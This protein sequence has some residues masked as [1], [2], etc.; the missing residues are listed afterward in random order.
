MKKWIFG[1]IALLLIL[2][3]FF[4]GKANWALGVLGQAALNI[5]GLIP[6]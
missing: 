6:G 4:P 5:L 1:S 2:A 3:A